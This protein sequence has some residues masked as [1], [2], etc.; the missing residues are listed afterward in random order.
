MWS[1]CMHL[2]QV[3]LSIYI[4]LIV[5]NIFYRKAAQL[6]V[7]ARVQRDFLQVLKSLLNLNIVSSDDGDSMRSETL[8]SSVFIDGESI[9]SLRLKPLT[10]GDAPSV[11]V[12]VL[13]HGHDDAFMQAMKSSVA[14]FG[15][16][17]VRDLNCKDDGGHTEATLERTVMY[18]CSSESDAINKFERIAALSEKYFSFSSVCE[19]CHR[20]PRSRFL[21]LKTNIEST[22]ITL[23]VRHASIGPPCESSTKCVACDD[24]KSVTVFALIADIKADISISPSSISV[25]SVSSQFPST[26]ENSEF[27]VFSTTIILQELLAGS[28][29][30]PTVSLEL[31][32]SW[33][34]SKPWLQPVHQYMQTFRHALCFPS[35]CS[36]PLAVISFDVNA[37]SG[38]LT[39]SVR[40]D[41]MY[42]KSLSEAERELILKRAASYD[43]ERVYTCPAESQ[44]DASMVQELCRQHLSVASLLICVASL[45]GAQWDKN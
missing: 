40:I 45:R 24:Q 32:E 21:S 33:T 27:L 11:P 28:D 6:S 36:T 3:L 20:P 10:I 26:K 18:R 34:K 25:E 17:Q 22:T 43:I 23:H 38:L 4:I 39:I 1:N 29:M 7:I 41:N 44:L 2:L 13:W 30:P 12:V 15:K 8:C 42:L 5:S 31:V 19:K 14:C 16:I 35:H 37:D 9:V